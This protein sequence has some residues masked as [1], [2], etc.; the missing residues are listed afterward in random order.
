MKSI[1]ET[2]QIN[3][4]NIKIIA[5]VLMFINH[6]HQ[7]FNVYGAPVWLTWLGRPVFPMFLFI[8]AESF[9]HTKNVKKLLIRLLA[10]SIGMTVLNNIIG[11]IFPHENVQLINNAFGTFFIATLYMFLADML[12]NAFGKSAR[13]AV[14]ATA[15]CLVPI[16]TAIPALVLTQLENPPYVL[17]R[18]FMH[19]PSLILVEGGFAMVLIGVLFYLFR[20]WRMLQVAVLIL[21]SILA[22]VSNSSSPQWM[23]VFAAI[24]MLLYNGERGRGM[25]NFFYIFYPAHI[26]LLYIVSALLQGRLH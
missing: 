2:L 25:K 6:I 7:M 16:I 12:K 13:K 23:M 24:P 15:L 8:M 5:V 21:F 19:V 3:A 20:K 1:R 18:I 14:F 4:T 10:F 11:M 26:Y 17:I 22:F 9:Y